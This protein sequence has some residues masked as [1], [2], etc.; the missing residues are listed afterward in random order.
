MT[1]RLSTNPCLGVIGHGRTKHGYPRIAADCTAS[2][3][4]VAIVAKLSARIPWSCSALIP[5]AFC[6]FGPF[7]IASAFAASAAATSALTLAFVAAHVASSSHAATGHVVT[8]LLAASVAAWAAWIW[9][10]IRA[11]KHLV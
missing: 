9:L 7:V 5:L 4:V 11:A 8:V 10:S 1:T 6:V 2:D 3:S